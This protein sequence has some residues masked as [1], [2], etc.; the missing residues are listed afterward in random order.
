MKLNRVLLLIVFSCATLF[1][2]A[3]GDISAYVNNYVGPYIAIADAYRVSGIHNRLPVHLYAYAASD[4]TARGFLAINLSVNNKPNAGY[5]D[6]MDV[7]GAYGISKRLKYSHEENSAEATALAEGSSIYGKSSVAWAQDDVAAA[8]IVP[9]IPIDFPINPPEPDPP[10]DSGGC[11][12]GDP[13]P[14]PSDSG[15][16]GSGDPPPDPPDSAGIGGGSDDCDCDCDCCDDDG[17]DSGGCD[18]GGD[19]DDCD[20]DCNDNDDGDDSGGCDDDG[21]DDDCDCNDDDD[22]DDSGGCS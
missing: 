22:G 12:I 16:C 20:C 17:D 8:T 15:S 21:D 3:V 14:D 5:H 9:I 7:N 2:G 13:P 4:N 6:A 11:G 19:D 10:D 1:V 18:D